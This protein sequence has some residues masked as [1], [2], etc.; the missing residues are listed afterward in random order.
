M[1]NMDSAARQQYQ[2]NSFGN[3][4]TQLPTD[5]QEAKMAKMAKLEQ[6]KLA[7]ERMM[8]YAEGR[9][10]EK[11]LAEYMILQKQK[12]IEEQQRKRQ[13]GRAGASSFVPGNEGRSES[14]KFLDGREEERAHGTEPSNKRKCESY[15]GDYLDGKNEGVAR[16]KA[17]LTIS[18]DLLD[19]M[20][21]NEMNAMINT[22]NL[23]VKGSNETQAVT[24]EMLEKMSLNEIEAKMAKLEQQK[25]ANERMMA[26]AEGRHAEK[27]LAEYMILQKQKEIEEQQRKRQGGRAGA[28]SFVPGNEGRSESS[29]FLD[30]REEERAHGTEPSNKR[31]CESYEGDYLDG[32]NEGVARK[33]AGL[34]ISMD[35][36]DKMENNEMNAMINTCNLK[37]KGSNETQAVTTEM[38][39]KMSLNKIEAMI[40]EYHIGSKIG[41]D[42]SLGG[43]KKTGRSATATF[44]ATGSFGIHMEGDSSTNCITL[45]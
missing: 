16:K 21:N 34:T 44:T 7:N 23:K 35:L 37:V 25:L 39:E 27:Y 3:K 14:S 4:P 18:M 11:Y 5:G 41:K 8:A 29:K 12:E 9:H 15:E 42:S 10:A 19:K 32:K 28:S 45:E 1:Y 17:G 38:L 26:Y 36:L 30:G 43:S 33:K 2:M 13:G 24:T 22:C 6:Q 31:K 20:E 40:A